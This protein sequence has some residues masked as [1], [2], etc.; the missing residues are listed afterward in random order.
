MKLPV[1]FV[2][3]RSS[4][5]IR[6]IICLVLLATSYQ[7]PVTSAF[8]Q[9]SSDV[10][11]VC[12]SENKTWVEIDRELTNAG[13][14]DP[15]THDDAELQTYNRTAC[16]TPTLAPAGATTNPTP[17]P[18][19][20]TAGKQG[21]FT[22]GYPLLEGILCTT[23]MI[24]PIEP[25][26]VQLNTGKLDAQGN[27]IIKLGFTNGKLG[28][29]MGTLTSLTGSLYDQPPTSTGYYLA[30]LGKQLRVVP[31][32]YAESQTTNIGGSGDAILAPVLA[33]WKT[34]RNFSYLM[35]IIVFLVVGFMIMFR[36]KINPQTVIS[37][38]A[39]LPGLVVGL[40]LVTFSYFLAALMVDLSFVGIQLII[41]IFVSSGAPNALGSQQE[42]QNI[43]ANSNLLDLFRSAFRFG[44]NRAD[45]YQG[46]QNIL[47]S[48]GSGAGVSSAVTI[49]GVTGLITVIIAGLVGG[50]AAIPV[51]LA[52]G[53]LLGLT[54]GITGF[55]PVSTAISLLVPVILIIGLMVQFFRLL[56][57]L[58]YSYISILIFTIL[59]P[60][61][62][63]YSSIPGRGGAMSFW[64][65]NILGNALVFPGVMATFLFAGL[66]LGQT[67]ASTWRA[68]PPLFGG[69]PTDLLRL[70]IAYAFIMGSPAIPDMIKKAVGVKDVGELTQAAQAGFSAGQGIISYGYQRATA[71]LAAAK[72]MRE[73]TLA[74][75][76]SEGWLGATGAN[77]NPP[78]FWQRVAR[79]IPTSGGGGGGR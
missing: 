79:V 43:A 69:L 25:C 60:V 47:T 22:L 50:L 24:N 15:R 53:G 36:Q 54:A 33:V 68:T 67:E 59:G 38:Q 26:P 77:A 58:I 73:R 6:L 20:W 34:M 57:K 32:V 78:T 2:I 19:Q 11:A 41:Q 10:I 45:L 17:S 51:G 49:G 63:M 27:P 65:K 39:A 55:D 4:F 8:A 35:F 76:R 52:A 29:A 42:L 64:W 23:T 72:G 28:G 48:V 44:G 13:N 71:P 31:E 18:I 14:N 7:L 62:I 74:T 46:V 70:I 5:V 1:L 40:I 30:D 56:F 21:A 16:P 66:I 37:V 9:S 75:A 12:T 3:R 61:I